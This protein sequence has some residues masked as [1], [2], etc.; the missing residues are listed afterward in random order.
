[1]KSRIL[2]VSASIGV[3]SLLVIASR[4][5]LPF[6]GMSGVDGELVHP[7]TGIVPLMTIVFSLSAITVFVMLGKRDEVVYDE[8]TQEYLES[9]IWDYPLIVVENSNLEFNIE[10]PEERDLTGL[11]SNGNGGYGRGRAP[12]ITALSSHRAIDEL[13]YELAGNPAKSAIGEQG[14]AAGERITAGLLYDYAGQESFNDSGENHVAELDFREMLLKVTVINSSGQLPP[15]LPDFAGRGFELAE[16]LAARVRPGVRI[17]GLEGL[18][19][20]GKTT[21]AIKLAHEVACDYPDAQVYIDLKGTSPLPLPVSEAQARIIRTFL[22]TARLPE[23]EGELSR[24]YQSVLTGKRILLLLDNAANSQQVA[25]LLPPEGCLPVITSRQHISLPEIFSCTLDSLNEPEAIDLLNRLIPRL[26]PKASQVAELCGR[27]PLALRLSAGTLTQHPEMTIDEYAARIEGTGR[28]SRPIEAV[29]M[30]SYALLSPGLQK[31]WRMLA[32]FTDTFDVPAAAALWK[33]NPARAARA[34]NMLLANSLIDRNRNTRRFRLH[35]KMLQYADSR[36][37]DDERD[38]A[39]Y[40][41]SAHYQ[42]VLHEAG[43]LYEQGG[44]YLKQGLDMLDLE[45]HNIQAGQV[46]AAVNTSTNRYACELCNSYP[47]AGKYLL[48]LRQHPRERIRWS[49]SALEAAKILRRRKAVARHLISL[50]NSYIDLSEYQHAIDCCQQALLL[51]RQISD[52]RCEADAL[53][54]LGTAYFIGGG[55]A[56]AREFHESALEIARA[57]EDHR[58]EA[59]ALGSLGLSQQALGDLNAATMLFD[60]QLRVAREI[61]DKR[62][63]AFALGGLGMS[64]LMLGDSQMAVELLNQQLEITK[65]IGDRRGEANALNNL[66][67][68]YAGHK[69]PKNA[70][71]LHRQALAMARELA[72]S[73][74]EAAALG[75]LG[76]AYYIDGD[77][78]IAAQFFEQ[79]LKIA[80]EIGDQRNEC[81]ALINL[82]EALTSLGET[83]RAIELLNKAFNIARQSEDIQGQA[84]A[85]FNLALALDRSGDRTH[86]IYQAETSLE[87]FEIGDLPAASVVR[88]KLAEWRR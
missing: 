48:E 30:T 10:P 67:S 55:P 5:I 42:S 13:E 56:R 63:E 70:V 84:N 28:A 6:M 86:A 78:G 36:L 29:L 75:G 52:Y 44:E 62:N 25:A 31:L 72:D 53:N 80:A 41:H 59:V 71:E 4:W 87:L 68:A 74:S 43:A 37:A 88:E 21:L 20:I 54:G 24:L 18:G 11:K 50:G 47:D 83:E 15:L 65:E 46:W 7:L 27:M 23:N 49:E 81:Y 66:G 2:I 85:L 69:D 73:R 8:Q 79:Q 39:T 14:K 26:G 77:P 16:L 3:L 12:E 22:P 9:T 19:G 57:I 32:V 82:G 76:I 58:T 35:D 40:L 38:K 64:H 1:M 33:I 17:L 34:L 51:A 45:W 60:Q 61:G